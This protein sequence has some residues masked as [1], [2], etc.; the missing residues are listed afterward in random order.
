MTDTV[1]PTWTTATLLATLAQ[2]RARLR[3]MG[4]QRLGLF[5]SYARG[6]QTPS[7]DV[8]LLLSIDAAVFTW[9][10]WMDVWNYLEDNL[11]IGV[12]LVPEADL[13][14]ELR[15]QVMREVRCVEEL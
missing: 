1:R 13:R 14:E 11:G 8:D 4:V 10:R 15:P 7:S 9:A 2:H 5:G 3:E 12:D 6:D